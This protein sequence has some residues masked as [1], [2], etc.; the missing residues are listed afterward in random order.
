MARAKLIQRNYIRFYETAITS[1]VQT[2]S[3]NDSLSNDF[4][5]NY[6]MHLTYTCNHM[7]DL[8]FDTS[9]NFLIALKFHLLSLLL[10]IIR[11]LSKVF[12]T[13]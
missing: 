12:N 8:N 13:N 3:I 6:I 10:Y 7:I 1:V 5:M 4:F 9:I 2:D 11:T